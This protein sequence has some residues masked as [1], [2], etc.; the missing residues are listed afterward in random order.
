[1]QEITEKKLFSGTKL[2]MDS[3]KQS[4]TQTWLTHHFSVLINIINTQKIAK[5][6]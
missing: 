2:A 1:M 3:K 4:Q 5:I 6:C